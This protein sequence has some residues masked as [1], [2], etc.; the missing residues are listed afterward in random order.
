MDEVIKKYNAGIH[1]SAANEFIKFVPVSGL[2]AGGAGVAVDVKAH[3]I[4][5]IKNVLN[6]FVLTNDIFVEDKYD[7]T[8]H[9]MMGGS[10]SEYDEY[11]IKYLKYKTK[12]IELKK[13]MAIK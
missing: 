8:I 12:Y 2:A 13:I 1:D 3:L 9:M 5:S 4:Q 11:R 7:S 6:N 10:S